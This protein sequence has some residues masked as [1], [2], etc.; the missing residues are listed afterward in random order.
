MSL[1]QNQ[2]LERY[3]K[4]EIL[5]KDQDAVAYEIEKC[6]RDPVHFI[7]SW[8]STYDP[9]NQPKHFPFVLYDFQI[10]TIHWLEQR[11]R[12]K[13][14]GLVEKS[15]DLGITNM[16]VAWAVHHFLFDNGFSALFGSRKEAL[17]DNFTMDSIFGKIRYYLYRLPKF[18]IPEGLKEGSKW[19]RHMSIT[20]P[21][22][23]NQMSGEST[24]SN[25]GRGGRSSICFID[26]AA[27]IEH[28]ER[29]YAAISE[30]SDSIISLSTPNGKGNM[31]AFLRFETKIPTLSLHWSRHPNKDQKWYDSKKSQMKPWQVAA[32]LDLSYEM[33]LEGKVYSRFDRRYHVSK[34]IIYCNPDYEQFVSHDFGILDPHATIFGQITTE[35]LIE[36]W[37]CYELAEQDIGFHIPITMGSKPAAIRTVD[38]QTAMYIEKV[39]SKVPMGHKPDHYGD[40]SGVAR[41]A[42]SKRTCRDAIKEITGQ[43]MKST[44]RN[45]FDWR[46]KCTDNLLKLRQNSRTGEWYSIVRVSPDCEKFIDAMFNYEYDAAGDKLNDNNLKPKHNWASHLVTAFEYFA[47]NRFP[48]QNKFDAY[49]HTRIR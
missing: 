30:N 26:E 34:E 11:Y 3:K 38:P 28:S 1:I 35:G 33:S 47:I 32:E 9:R 40:H 6:R 2:Y 18:L 14:N 22:N 31:F 37:Q 48:I 39:L 12:N 8:G 5:A 25:F 45:Q 27:H 21:I 15:R 24:N 41:T 13:E 20:N 43:W 7:N 49:T 17:V 19:D 29:I 36:I 4:L 46:I 44:G 10:E 42:N 16:A 23:G